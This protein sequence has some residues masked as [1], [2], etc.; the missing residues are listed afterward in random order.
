M[1]TLLFRVIF[2]LYVCFSVHIKPFAVYIKHYI[3]RRYYCV[4]MIIMAEWL[5]M[6]LSVDSKFHFQ[7][8][9]KKRRCN[10]QQT[11][12]CIHYIFEFAFGVIYIFTYKHGTWNKI[13]H[14]NIIKPPGICMY[15]RIFFF[16]FL[17][18]LPVLVPNAVGWWRRVV[19][20]FFLVSKS[21][22]STG[23]FLLLFPFDNHFFLLKLIVSYPIMP[24]TCGKRRWIRKHL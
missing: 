14:K 1:H 13:K 9:K 19:V 12:L 8:R 11:R 6:Y 23:I 10:F 18:L 7:C 24:S 4:Y 3:E 16:S 15:T 5:F 21:T 2:G 22:I 20:T 17:I